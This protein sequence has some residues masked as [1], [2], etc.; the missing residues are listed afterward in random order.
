M[1][2]E[3]PLAIGVTVMTAMAATVELFIATKELI[4]PVPL[5]ANPIDGLLF[6]QLKVVPE[7]LPVKTIAVV[8]TLLQTV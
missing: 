1:G 4:F 5:A 3:Q 7:T 8:L 2:P 6:V